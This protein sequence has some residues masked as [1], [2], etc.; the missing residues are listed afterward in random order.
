[1]LNL[2]WTAIAF[3]ISVFIGFMVFFNNSKMGSN[4]ILLQNSDAYIEF[5]EVLCV[6]FPK[7]M[8]ISIA[9]ITTIMN[10]YSPALAV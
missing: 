3:L 4:N 7:T 10:V 6:G 1:M 2:S 8:Q 9:P 5:W